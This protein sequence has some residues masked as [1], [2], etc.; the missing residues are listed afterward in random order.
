MSGGGGVSVRLGRNEDEELED[1]RSE[2]GL[3]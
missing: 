3:R 2:P 1:F